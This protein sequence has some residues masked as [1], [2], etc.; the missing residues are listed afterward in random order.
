MV[1]LI[2]A[3]SAIWEVDLPN[4]VFSNTISML[5]NATFSALTLNI[6]LSSTHTD[7][8][9]Y[10]SSPFGHWVDISNSAYLK[11]MFLFS[12]CKILLSPLS[13]N[14]IPSFLM[15]NS[16]S[17]FFFFFIFFQTHSWHTFSHCSSSFNLSA[18]PTGSTCSI[19]IEFVYFSPSLILPSLPL[20]SLSLINAVTSQYGS[21]LHLSHT[22]YK[23]V[24]IHQPEYSLPINQIMW[25]WPKTL[26]WF[27]FF[28]FRLKSIFYFILFF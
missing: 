10:S 24:I 13:I 9:A 12:L 5:M 3:F 27:R 18:N 20:F 28:A 14:G 11:W 23:L 16:D 1:N 22:P 2:G 15:F 21:S 4:S 17:F 6:L 7:P 19:S 8:V 25:L 26:Q